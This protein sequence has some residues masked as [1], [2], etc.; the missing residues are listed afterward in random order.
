MI[1]SL[2]PGQLPL[3]GLN[4]HQRHRPAHGHGQTVTE[5]ELQTQQTIRLDFRLDLGVLNET[6][7]ATA[8]APLLNT[9]DA[10]LGTVIENQ[11]IVELPL[12]GRNF[13]RMVELTPNVSA[14]FADSGTS[15]TRQGG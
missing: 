12:N 6:V 7:E 1:E 2:H 15:S 13:L 10:V 3:A 9:V 8:S 14:S 11:R 4:G 5:V